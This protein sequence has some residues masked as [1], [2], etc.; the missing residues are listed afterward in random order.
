V[1]PNST[2]GLVV[3]VH[4]AAAAVAV[5]SRNAMTVTAFAAVAPRCSVRSDFDYTVR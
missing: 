5:A 4:A 2:V 3:G 1:N